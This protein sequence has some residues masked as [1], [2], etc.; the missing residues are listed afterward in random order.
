[1][2]G[3]PHRGRLNLLTGLLGMPPAALFSKIQGGSEIPDGLDATGDV[4]SHLSKR[5]YPTFTLLLTYTFS[6]PSGITFSALRW[7]EER[8]EGYSSSQSLSSR[9]DAP[10]N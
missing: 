1:M 5:M 7:S 2:L 3:M 4:V 9:Y 8:V 10:V 6:F